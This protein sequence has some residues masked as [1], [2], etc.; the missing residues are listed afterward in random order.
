MAHAK[1]ILVAYDGSEAGRRGLDAAADLMGYG[2]VLAVVGIRSSLSENPLAEAS[3]FLSG[4]HTSA[5][6]VQGNGRTADT[7]LDTAT[8]VGA[9][10][11]VV[12]A[13]DGSLDTLVRR[14][15][16]NVLVVR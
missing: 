5:H 10:V 3:R 14:A 6:Y 16:C 7:V 1:S 2:S 8:D 13:S 15:P 4:R 11:I 9:D 12:P